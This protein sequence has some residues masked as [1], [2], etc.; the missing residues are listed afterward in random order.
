MN[1]LK[2]SVPFSARDRRTLGFGLG[3]VLAVIV[4]GRGY[5]AWRAWERTVR[6]EAGR[7]TH[8]LERLT[9]AIRGLPATRDS[10][11]ARTLRLARVRSSLISAPTYPDADAALVTHLSSLIDEHPVRV[12]SMSLRSSTARSASTR[13]V[14]VRVSMLSGIEGILEV[15]RA[16]EVAPLLLAV[17]EL[18]IEPA[19]ATQD[20]QEE[21]LRVDLV[22]EALAVIGESRVSYA[23]HE[24][25]P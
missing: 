11:E 17:R 20:S 13:R 3:A 16:I 25:P 10:V 6:E 19:G 24:L 1:E 5:P 4:L 23:R 9:A 7:S 15:L 18:S 14:A 12:L 2:T 21:Q 22:V 8:E